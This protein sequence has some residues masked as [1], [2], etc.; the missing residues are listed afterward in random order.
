MISEY[1]DS[2]GPRE[3]LSQKK[4]NQTKP[5]KGERKASWWEEEARAS[6]ET[7][8]YVALTCPVQTHGSWP[9]L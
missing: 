8:D 6:V 2:Q 7:G 4:Q 9:A 1:E 3:N 5:K